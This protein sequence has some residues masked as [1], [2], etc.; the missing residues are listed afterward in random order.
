M[1]VLGRG[2][3]FNR[4]EGL[5]EASRQTPGDGEGAGEVG[6]VIVV[7]R[8]RLWQ[9]EAGGFEIHVEG[10]EQP[11]QAAVT[12]LPENGCLSEKIKDAGGARV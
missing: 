4:L 6:K 10:M 9:D 1:V 2:S 8:I 12:D 7:T 3:E 11:G 5:S